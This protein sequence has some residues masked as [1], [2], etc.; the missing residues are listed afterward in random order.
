MSKTFKDKIA[1]EIVGLPYE[2]ACFF[3][4]LS[5]VRALPFISATG[6]FEI[7]TVSKYE[8]NIQ[9]KRKNH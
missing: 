3:V 2:D 4:W 5:A 1:E 7:W 8:N 6:N 9:K